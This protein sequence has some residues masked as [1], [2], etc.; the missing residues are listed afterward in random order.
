M[1]NK[2]LMRHRFTYDG[3]RY[4]VYGHSPGELIDKAAAKKR[5]LEE[6]K[7]L[8]R[9]VSV[10]AWKR[11]WLDTYKKNT[12]TKKTLDDYRSVLSHLNLSMPMK[13]VRP[14][15]L[16]KILNGL[17]GRSES[18][19]NKFCILTKELFED[20]VDNGIC[21]SNPAKKLSKPKGYKRARR[22]LTLDERRLIEE[23][24]PFSDAG[25]YV[26]LMLYAGLRPGETGIVQGK[27]VDLANMMLHVRGTKTKNAD[28]FVP[29]SDK[30]RPY[31]A[32]LKRN[33]YAVTNAYGDPS[34]KESRQGLW[35]RFKRELN[36]AAG[37]EVGRR[38]KH[39]PHDLPLEDLLADDLEPYL[40]RHTFCTDLEAAG[41]PIN[42]AR[43]LMGHSSITIT[44]QIYTHRSDEA[45]QDAAAKMNRY[46]PGMRV[47]E[48][49]KSKAMG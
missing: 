41:V 37:A 13:D 28:R 30:L 14:V 33:E 15:H 16:Q 19:I 25:R 3:K 46:V 23:V 44:S 4:A 5:E 42:V 8:E 40:L 2:E 38:S 24:A 39:S 7:R 1:G 9:N 21:V 45:M 29:I 48:G 6:G 49:K 12:V 22:P 43:D 10:N 20:A 31:L 26:A 27:D 34:T 36:I 11:E 17:S 18:L 35:R 47:I 32:D